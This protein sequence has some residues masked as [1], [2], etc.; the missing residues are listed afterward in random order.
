VNETPLTAE[1]FHSPAS[2]SRTKQ[3]H[4]AREPTSM[5]QNGHVPNSTRP[6]CGFVTAS[7]TSAPSAS[8]AMSYQA[9]A[10]TSKAPAPSISESP[11]STA[12]VQTTLS[13]LTRAQSSSAL[14][15]LTADAADAPTVTF[16]GS[17]RHS[18]GSASSELSLPECSPAHTAQAKFESTERALAAMV[19][20]DLARLCEMRAHIA[21]L[22]EE[23]RTLIEERSSKQ[24]PLTHK[25]RPST[26]VGAGALTSHAARSKR[27]GSGSHEGFFHDS[28]T[29]G[30]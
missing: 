18:T 28:H 5:P 24:T 4:V 15:G 12:R 3:A 25:R 14:P 6:G 19:K 27:G 20:A 16:M 22:E 30:I 23:R 7:A 10:G 9:A 1:L 8:S 13:A 21:S 26:R 11:R 2:P 17:R 29:H